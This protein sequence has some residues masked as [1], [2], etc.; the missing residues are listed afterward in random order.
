MCSTCDFERLQ[1]A[2]MCQAPSSPCHVQVQ[3][4]SCSFRATPRLRLGELFEAQ[5]VCMVSSP[6]Q[7][8]FSRNHRVCNKFEVI[9]CKLFTE[10]SCGI[11][12]SCWG[13]CRRF[14]ALPWHHHF[15]SKGS[16]S[17]GGCSSNPLDVFARTISLLSLYDFW[18]QVFSR[19]KKRIYI[20]I[21]RFGDALH[22][23]F[24]KLLA[25]SS[26]H[27]WA[28][29]AAHCRCRNGPNSK[30]GFVPK[31]SVEPLDWQIWTSVFDL[32]S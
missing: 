9:C 4:S 13:K 20:Y 22:Q 1:G 16:T 19:F 18:F 31:I 32:Y 27:L 12:N 26:L 23:K 21:Y 28:P 30:H 24:A 5:G 7:L 8:P 15:D 25:P 3:S 6:T 2:K 17:H 14:P 10:V 11:L 29:R